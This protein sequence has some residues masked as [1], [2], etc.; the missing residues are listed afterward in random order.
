MKFVCLIFVI[1]FFLLSPP[2][3]MVLDCIISAASVNFICQ[4]SRHMNCKVEIFID[5]LFRCDLFFL[6]NCK[7]SSI[8]R[9]NVRQRSLY[10]EFF[11]FFQI[12]ANEIKM[13]DNS[14]QSKSKQID[15]CRHVLYMQSRNN[16]IECRIKNNMYCCFIS[17]LPMWRLLS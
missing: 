10:R 4:I 13:N 15:R 1:I 12:K 5:I 6:C 7:Y 17:R 14:K 11:L 3:N 16:E 8:K 2:L 9:R